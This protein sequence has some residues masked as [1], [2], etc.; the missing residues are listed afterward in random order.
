VTTPSDPK[1]ADILLV[2]ATYGKV[3]E[4]KHIA[5]NG[6][7]TA[8]EPI[9]EHWIHV[10]AVDLVKRRSMSLIM[11]SLTKAATVRA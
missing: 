10:Q 4:R 1:A 3:L 11:A 7:D 2:G 6:Y 5:T 8:L 9:Q